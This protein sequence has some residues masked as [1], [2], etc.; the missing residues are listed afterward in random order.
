[1]DIA[2]YLAWSIFAASLGYGLVA[3]FCVLKFRKKLSSPFV[4][5]SVRGSVTL[6]KPLHG[7]DYGMKQNLLSFCRQDY[8]NYQV[9]F[10]V[11]SADDPAIS[12]VR[13]VM[14]ACPD[15]DTVLV[16]NGRWNGDNPKVSNLINMDE[17]A[18]NDI[19]V[20]SDSDMR[21]E[22]DYLDRVVGE[23]SSDKTGLV[24]CLYKGTPA[25]GLA[26][27]LG[28]MFISQW[29]TP[30]ALIAATFGEMKHCFGTTMAVKR[31]VLEK[32]G[33]FEAIAG[34]LADDYTL[35]RLVREA[36]L[37]IRLANVVVENIIEETSLRSLIVH[38]LRW[39]RT[40][41]SVEPL[42]FLSTF[43]T[44]TLPL[45]LILTILSAIAGHDW[46]WIAAPLTLAIIVR[47]ALH[48]STKAS[49][50]SK[51]PVSIWIIPIRDLLSFF[52][53]LLCYTGRTVNWRNSELSVGKGGKINNSSSVIKADTQ[54]EK[55]TVSEPPVLRRI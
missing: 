3:V 26:S 18:N 24:T 48:F 10:G 55:D 8:P 47:V 29:F 38:E 21:V 37:D 52:V 32:I 31:N 15:V 22:P 4:A 39:A 12:V 43:L 2:L 45:S 54:N 17:A 42:G 46:A 11:T 6:Y 36:G 27:K 44:D 30:S 1:M 53:R 28:A 23:F 41:R 51:H 35:G 16:I 40:I 9:V 25:P 50:I 20:I 13:E 34:N 49:F 7:L 33:G 14:S 19:L 5:P